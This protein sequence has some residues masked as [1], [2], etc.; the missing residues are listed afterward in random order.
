M[1]IQP[2]LPEFDLR[3]TSTIQL[4]GI[5]FLVES[6]ESNGQSRE[7]D[8]SD[9]ITMKFLGRAQQGQELRETKLERQFNLIR[10]S[11]RQMLEVLFV[12]LGI[13]LKLPITARLDRM[14]GKYV[15][16]RTILA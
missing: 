1:E 11:D 9:L 12:S 16:V 4:R 5:C 7:A 8:G 15:E 3:A 13:D 14:V 10:A 6:W 2:T